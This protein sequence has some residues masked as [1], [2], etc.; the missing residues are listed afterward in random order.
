MAGRITLALRIAEAGDE[1][2]LAERIGTSVA[3]RDSVAAAFGV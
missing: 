3:S 1:A 2:A